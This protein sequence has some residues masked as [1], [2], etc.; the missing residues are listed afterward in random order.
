MTAKVS[1]LFPDAASHAQ[2]VT[3]TTSAL[4]LEPADAAAV[5]LTGT[6]AAA[7]DQAKAVEAQADRVLR[8]AKAEDPE[9]VDEVQALRAK[10]SAQVTVATIGPK[11]LDVLTALGATPAARAKTTKAEPAT[12]AASNLGRLRGA[13]RKP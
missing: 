9:L 12:K 1:P 6:Y 2:A 13:R 5:R 10:L 3:D 11:L 4:T 8:R 7:L